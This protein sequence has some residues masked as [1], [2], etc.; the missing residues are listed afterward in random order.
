MTK[1]LYRY[2]HGNAFW[3]LGFFYSP[4]MTV[5]NEEFLCRLE[6]THAAIT[7]ATS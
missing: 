6:R 3:F 5:R 7:K 1:W 4:K 2:R